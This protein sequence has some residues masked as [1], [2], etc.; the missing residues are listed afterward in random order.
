MRS[1]F[2][3][4]REARPELARAL[5]E[6]VVACRGGALF[7]RFLAALTRGGGGG[8]SNRSSGGG[9]ESLQATAASSSSSS[10]LPR[11][12][13]ASSHSDPLR[14]VG[15]MLGWAH[16]AAAGERDALRSL[17]EGDVDDDDEIDENGKEEVEVADDEAPPSSF[18]SP[19]WN[20]LPSLSS[21]VDRATAP[22]AAP[23]ATRVEGV[24]QS[25]P[26]LPPLLALRLAALLSFYSGTLRRVIGE[27][28]G[29]GNDN[30][31]KKLA[32]LPAAAAEGASSA[33]ASAA[34]SVS[35]KRDALL[36]NPPRP[37]GGMNG[38]SAPAAVAAFAR[39]LA[40]LSAAAAEGG[41]LGGGGGE[42]SSSPSSSSSSPLSVATA[43]IQ[44][45]LASI[46]PAVSAGAAA[47]GL[48]GAASAVAVANG[49]FAAAQALSSPSSTTAV[50]PSSSSSPASPSRSPSLA[51]AAAER[52]RAAASKAALEAAGL[53]ADELLSRT[54]MSS[55]GGSGG[56]GCSLSEALSAL[57]SAVSTEGPIPPLDSLADPQARRQALRA[58]GE[59]VA[60]AYEAGCAALAVSSASASSSS[61][62]TGAVS[63]GDL[64]LLL[65]L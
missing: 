8:G 49:C 5:L 39:E 29:N 6:E 53:A 36:R 59:A 2:A 52:L 14:Y 57:S 58:A 46:A 34:A 23:L 28:D 21:L 35:A 44:A 56:G 26:P 12:M 51:S 42:G 50:A 47:A 55:S 16:Q 17:L 7:Q 45:A 61:P 63:P 37:E 10:S 20:L 43:A 30:G 60:T 27:S 13:E 15:D 19:S 40:E 3:A 54:G 1:A 4:L 25:R 9:G 32:V 65:G 22:A 38:L 33:A 62:P 18:S 31:V 64:R 24:I 41:A 11:P 48:R